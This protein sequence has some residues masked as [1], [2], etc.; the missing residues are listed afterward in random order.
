MDRTTILKAKINTTL[1]LNHCTLERL[2]KVN[3]ISDSYMHSSKWSGTKPAQKNLK[4]TQIEERG[5]E[6]E[7]MLKE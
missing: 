5:R 6:E 4:K 1:V 2:P 3:T 7:D